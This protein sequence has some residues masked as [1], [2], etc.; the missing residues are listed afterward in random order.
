MVRRI[1]RSLLAVTLAMVCFTAG[2]GTVTPKQILAGGIK[3]LAFDSENVLDDL[4]SSAGFDIT[5]Y[6]FRETAEPTVKVINVVEY[7]YSFRENF[8]DMQ[9]RRRLR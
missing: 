3:A 8:S 5:D 1:K 6:P 2:L 4:L 9:T 7:C